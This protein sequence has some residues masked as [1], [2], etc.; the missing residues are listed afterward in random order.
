[1]LSVPRDVS[2]AEL[3]AAYHRALLLLH[4][5]KNVTRSAPTPSTITISQ[6]K[7]AYITLSTP[8]LREKYDVSQR[9][10]LPSVPRPAQV[11]SLEDFEE[12]IEGGAEHDIWRYGCRCGGMYKITSLDMEKGHHL[13]ACDS[14]SEAIWVGYELCCS[15][16]EGNCIK[17]IMSTM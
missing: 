13:V 10:A 11:V 8:D 1:L 7:E 17:F 4:P 5:D 2:A 9:N 15:E 6:V 12:M 14:C 16:D 3:R